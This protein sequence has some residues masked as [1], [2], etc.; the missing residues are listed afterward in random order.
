MIDRFAHSRPVWLVAGIVLGLAAGGLFPHAPLHATAT[1]R[2]ESFA[3]ATGN[4]EAGIDA[5]YMLDFLTGDLRA[6]VLNPN[7]RAFTSTFMHNVM[8]DLK[9]EQG[10]SPRYLMVTGNADL[11]PT[12]QVQWGGSVLYVA[13]LSSGNMA[14]Y[15][16]PWNP[17]ALNRP[18]NPQS[19]LVL[20][21]VVPFRTTAVRGA[22]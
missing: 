4:V 2:Q 19:P 9:V 22:Q 17:A 3:I 12:G 1:D 7:N 5:I 16:M 10:K 20:L 11:R 14:V 13:E 21:Q 8:A 6:A 15:G 18:L